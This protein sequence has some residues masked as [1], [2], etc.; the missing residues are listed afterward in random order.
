MSKIIQ[1]IFQTPFR[2]LGQKYCKIQIP[3]MYPLLKMYYTHKIGQT[4]LLTK[5]IAYA[6]MK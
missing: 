3:T 4:E 2:H 6:I 1:T 5:P